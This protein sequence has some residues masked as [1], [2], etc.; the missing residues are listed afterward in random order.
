M[1]VLFPFERDIQSIGHALSAVDISPTDILQTAVVPKGRD[2]L[3]FIGYIIADR[4]RFDRIGKEVNMDDYRYKALQTLTRSRFDV[5]QNLTR[6]KR[7]RL[8]G[9]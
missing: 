7:R 4:L 1:P 5:A 8:R 9:G 3:S 2:N 6:E